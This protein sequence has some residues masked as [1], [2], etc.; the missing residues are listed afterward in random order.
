MREMLV[1]ALLPMKGNSERVPNKNTRLLLGKPLFFYVMES[2]ISSKYISKVIINSDSTE[3]LNMALENFG[4]EKII[5][6]SRPEFLLGAKLPM[7]PIIEYDLQFCDTEHF[8]QLHATTPLLKAGTID[9]AIE[10]YFEGLSDGYDSLMGVTSYQTRFYFSDGSPINHDPN[11][12]VPSQDMP[13]IYEDN[14]TFYINSKDNFYMRNN[15]VGMRPLFFP[16]NKIEAI[17]IDDMEDWFIAEALLYYIKHFQQ[18]EQVYDSS[19]NSC[20]GWQ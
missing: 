12:M 18:E 14:S 13:Y 10:K 15:R 3:I 19:N 6:I 11:I 8:I 16:V 1:T 2:I 17:D 9:C 4:E 5:P 7:T 20:K